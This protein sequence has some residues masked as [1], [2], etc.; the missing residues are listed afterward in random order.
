MR[1]Q[2]ISFIFALFTLFTFS[3]LLF[4][5]WQY[6]RVQQAKGLWPI[7]K[8]GLRIDLNQIATYASVPALLMP[9]LENNTLFLAITAVWFTF[10]WLLSAFMEIATPQF[11]TEYDTRPNRLFVEYLK[12]PKEVFGMLWRGYK[13]MLAAGLL[14]FAC[15]AT[16]ANYLFFNFAPAPLGPVWLRIIESFSYALVSFLCIRGTLKKRPINP[17]TVAFAGD[18]LVN[19]LALNSIYSLLYAIYAMKYEMSAEAVYGKMPA[20]TINRLVC[21]SAGIKPGMDAG[22]IATLHQQIASNHSG[23]PKNIVIIVEESLGAQYVQ[24]LGGNCLTPNL[25]R[26]YQEGWG[27]LQAYATGTRSVRGLEALSAGFPPTITQSVFKLPNAQTGFFT[28]AEALGQQYNYHSRFLYGGEAHFDNMKGFFLGNGF[29]EVIDGPLFKDP[30]FKGT[31]GYSDEDMFN[32]LDRLLQEDIGSNQ[33]TLTLAFSVSN[34][35]PW[36]YPAGRIHPQ[37]E[38]ASVENTVRYADHALGQFF[39]TAKTRD[40][41]QDTV[42]LVVA[43]HDSR[44]FGAELIPLKHFHIPALILGAGITPRLDERIISQI[45]LPV[46][47]LSLA[48]AS[49]VHPMIGQDLTRQSPNR[50]MMQYDN[51]YGYLKADQLLVLDPHRQATQFTYQAPDV[52]QRSLLDES[53]EKEALAHAIWPFSVYRDKSYKA[54]TANPTKKEIDMQNHPSVVG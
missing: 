42:F 53:L 8:G 46:T 50:A 14:L 29:K 26:L 37:D 33:P 27:F 28:I 44:V 31:W 30:Q 16:M 6:Q 11:I 36:E 25:D 18:G 13:G 22:T 5:A 1:I 43:D 23:S 35:S 21:E 17:S 19:S 52:F 10:W 54:F 48:S 7:L 38:P 40:Y 47:L 3:R 34:H 49:C 32:Q 24:T 12:H 45:D 41:W 39:E 15:M 9:W 51:R 20:E 2:L 4:I